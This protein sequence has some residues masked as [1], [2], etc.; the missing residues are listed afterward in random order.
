MAERECRYIFLL[1]NSASV[2]IICGI[3]LRNVAYI[4]LGIRQTELIYVL[5]LFSAD[6]V[7]SKYSNF[8]ILIQLMHR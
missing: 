7:L 4:H 3:L 1:L 6:C 2:F 5:S 8:N